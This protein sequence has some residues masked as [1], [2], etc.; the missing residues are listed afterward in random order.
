MTHPTTQTTPATAGHPNRL[1]PSPTTLFTYGTL[2][3]NDVLTAL[4]GRIP[5][6]IPALAPGW[7]AAAL[8]SRVYPGL[9]PA[10]NATASGLLLTDL[11]PTEWRILDLFEDDR[12]DLREIT[13]AS[14]KTGW[15]YTW[16]GGEVR[17][18]DWNLHHFTTQHLT[19][20]AARCARIAPAFASSATDR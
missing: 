20:Y 17:A 3:A 4:L 13:L 12:Y 2:Q 15:A 19:T 11:T 1:A 7:R 16:P 10:P 18:E 14:G 6:R 8:E 5:A 9:V